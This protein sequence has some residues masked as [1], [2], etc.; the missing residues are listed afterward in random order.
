ML[1]LAGNL[2]S[3]GAGQMV[4]DP[5]STRRGAQAPALPDPAL[6]PPPRS[7]VILPSGTGAGGRR[8]G[9][10][11]L[12]WDKL[13]D[14]V[15]SVVMPLRRGADLEIEVSL[16]A[17]GRAGG[18]PRGTLERVVKETLQQIRA[19]ILEEETVDNSPT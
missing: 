6:R 9:G 12:V 7:L 4:S 15:R 14:F 19:E 8:A 16:R 2:L 13:S 17:R 5:P 1:A 10:G 11:V 3:P 18:I